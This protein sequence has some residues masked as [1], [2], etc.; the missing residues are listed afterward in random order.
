[1][2]KLESQISRHQTQKLAWKKSPQPSAPDPQRPEPE[3]QQLPSD[4]TGLPIFSVQSSSDPVRHALPCQGR[5]GEGHGHAARTQLDAAAVAAETS[6]NFFRFFVLVVET[7]DRVAAV[8]AP[9]A[10][11]SKE[12]S[13]Q[14]AF[15]ETPFV[16]VKIFSPMQSLEY[17][18]SEIPG[19]FCFIEA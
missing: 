6:P 19:K 1:M 12:R 2:E 7:A 17:Y 15:A 3:R 10:V 14:S 13:L 4:V 16:Q 5:P 8:V 9:S 11:A 18:I